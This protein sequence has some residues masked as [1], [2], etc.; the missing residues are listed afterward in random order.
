[1]DTYKIH[2]KSEIK[3]VWPGKSAHLMEMQ[4]R[5]QENSLMWI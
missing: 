5:Y 2:L 3:L 4:E 1:M